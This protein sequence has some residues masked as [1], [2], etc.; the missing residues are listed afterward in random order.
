LRKKQETSNR[1]L[2]KLKSSGSNAWKKMKRQMDSALDELEKMY[3]QVKS[4]FK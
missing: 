2:E 1:K 3:D 4:R